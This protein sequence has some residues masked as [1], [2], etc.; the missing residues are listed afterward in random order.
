MK[1]PDAVII[2]R[3]FSA[4]VEVLWSMWTDPEYFREWYGPEGMSIPVAE[5]DVRPG[6]ARRICMEMK[7][8]DGP[9]KMW[10]TGEYRQV[11]ENVRL[12]YTEA[13]SDE[14]GNVSEAPNGG[15]AVTEVHVELEGVDGGTRVRMTHLGIPSDS[16]GAAGWNMAFDKLAK[17]LSS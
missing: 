3:V 9:M 14:D 8:P 16:P 6:G 15:H 11:V 13:L 5:M 12:V 7:T 1:D 2:E 17:H 10:F 4:P